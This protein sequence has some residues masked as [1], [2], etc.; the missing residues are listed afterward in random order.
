MVFWNFTI[1][2]NIAFV[3]PF[4]Q[5]HKNMNI[6]YSPFA[7]PLKYHTPST[8]T[9]IPLTFVVFIYYKTIC[10]LSQILKTFIE[11]ALDIEASVY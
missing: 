8:T 5:E 10:L 3:A 6:Y 7:W 4:S 1:L 9:K 11:L 2:Q